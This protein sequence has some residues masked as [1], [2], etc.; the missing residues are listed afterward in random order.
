MQQKRKAVE[1]V[2]PGLLWSTLV[3]AG[4]VASIEVREAWAVPAVGPYEKQGA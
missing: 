4:S 2:S 3:V 1:S